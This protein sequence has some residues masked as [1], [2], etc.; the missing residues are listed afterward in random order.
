M[1]RIVVAGGG[2]AGV[3]A[4]QELAKQLKRAHR[5]AGQPG[6][7]PGQAVEVVLLSR[8]NYFVFQPL[9]ADIISGTIETTHVVVPLRRMLPSCTVEVGLIESIDT[10]KRTVRLQRRGGGDATIVTYDA[11]VIA[12]GSITDF[13]A[14]PGMAEHAVGLRTMGDAFYLRNRALD[15]LEEARI[16]QDSGRRERLLTFVVVGGGSTGVEV[17][18]E[19]HDLLEL[20]ARSFHDPRVRP[21]VVLVHSRDLVVDEL[22]DR[23][24][25]YATGKLARAGIE[26]RLGRRLVAVHADRV[27]LSDGTQVATETVVSTVGNAPHP[28]LADLPTAH[29]ARGWLMPDTTFALPGLSNVWALGDCASIVDPSTGRPMP[30]TAQH[31]IREGPHAARNVLA[32]L[33]GRPQR[34]FGYQQLGM[35][36]SL[37]RFKAVGEIF[38]IKVSGLIAWFLWRTYYLMR[39]PSFDRRLRVAIDWT[40]ELLLQRDIVEIS[41]RRTRTRPGETPGEIPGEPVSVGARPDAAD[42]LTL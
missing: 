36:V 12:L 4:A 34:P 26:L 21:R 10:V 30:S 25:R 32:A 35:L 14:V 38:G 15:M 41:V 6:A 39:L 33:A 7:M 13:R 24:G 28:V 42:E 37:G 18:A 16:E 17:A 1:I 31:A 22:G 8:D 5:L 29:D 27:E 40:L 23:L 19:L 2:F 9:L 20:A 3:S 11:L